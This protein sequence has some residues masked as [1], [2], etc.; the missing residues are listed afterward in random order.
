MDPGKG[1]G[2]VV[3]TAP[4]PRHTNTVPNYRRSSANESPSEK[5]ARNIAQRRIATQENARTLGGSFRNGRWFDAAGRL[6]GTAQSEIAPIKWVRP[7]KLGTKG[8][9]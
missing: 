4:P 1:S 5:A 2:A 7:R 9:M 3:S 6:I 8:G